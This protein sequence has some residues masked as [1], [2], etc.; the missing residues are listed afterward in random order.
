MNKPWKVLKAY[1]ESAFQ[2]FKHFDIIPLASASMAQVHAATLHSGEEV[3][4]KDLR[5]GIEKI[6]PARYCTPLDDCKTR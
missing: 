3:V 5:P 2:R 4:V 1:G 6:Y